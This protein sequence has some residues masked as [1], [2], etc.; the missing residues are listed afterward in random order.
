MAKKRY[1]RSGIV[2]AIGSLAVG[3]GASVVVGVLVIVVGFALWYYVKMAIVDLVGIVFMLMGLVAVVGGAAQTLLQTGRRLVRAFEIPKLDTPV[4]S[5]KTFYL[6]LVDQ[7]W[8]KA[9]DCLAESAKD[10]QNSEIYQIVSDSTVFQHPHSELRELSLPTY[11]DAKSFGT[12]WNRLKE[13]MKEF[14]DFGSFPS[15]KSVRLV[16]KEQ[17]RAMVDVYFKFSGGWP[18]GVVERKQLTKIGEDWHITSGEFGTFSLHPEDPV[19]VEAKQEMSFR[20]NKHFWQAHRLLN[21]GNDAQALQ[22][23]KRGLSVGDYC[24]PEDDHPSA[25]IALLQDLRRTSLYDYY[26]EEDRPFAVAMA[27]RK[28]EDLYTRRGIQHKIDS[29]RYQQ[30]LS[31]LIAIRQEMS[32]KELW[33]KPESSQYKRL[34]EKSS[35]VR[36]SMNEVVNS[37]VAL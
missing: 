33:G 19:Y 28:I 10:S 24:L 20:H 18:D 32:D 4:N 21:Q 35:N 34:E 16:V 7:N 29:A 37:I 31:E 3:L 25:A 23:L 27:F 36:E 5:I 11:N 26:P 15:D 22:E 6:A 9:Y 2:P 17:D 14:G 30:L 1:V 8:Q 12:Y 13:R